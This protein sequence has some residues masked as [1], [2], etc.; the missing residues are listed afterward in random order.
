MA[1]TLVAVDSSRRDPPG[2]RHVRPSHRAL[3]A[4]APLR[5]PGVEPAYPRLG[6]FREVRRR[7]DP[8]RQFG[9]RYLD[10]LL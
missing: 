2:G 10:G 3:T 6:D 7:L 8:E 9:N 5:Q 4:R 1:R